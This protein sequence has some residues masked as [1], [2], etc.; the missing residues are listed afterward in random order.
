MRNDPKDRHVL[1]A[2]VAT[3]AEY[4]VTFNLRDFPDVALS[5]HHV[6]AIAPDAFLCQL[7]D[8]APDIL[9]QIIEDQAKA[10]RKPA[11]TVARVLQNLAMH[12]PEFVCLVTAHINATP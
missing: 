3:G 8:V 1:A 2:A 10:Q 4:I 7:L 6:Q 11:T 5:P 12:V 9:A